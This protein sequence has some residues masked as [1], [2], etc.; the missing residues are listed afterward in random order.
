M[1]LLSAVMR[2][3]NWLAAGFPSTMARRPLA[4]IGLGGGFAIQPQRNLLRDRIRTVAAVA[5]VGKDG[6]HVAIERNGTVRA[7]GG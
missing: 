1:P 7:Q 5:F 4:E 2:W 3:T 6:P